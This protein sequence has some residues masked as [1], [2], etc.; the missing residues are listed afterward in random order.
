MISDKHRDRFWKIKELYDTAEADLKNIGRDNQALVVTGINQCRYVGQHLLRAMTATDE[1]VI[2]E[3]LDAALRHTQRAIYDTNDSGIQYYV[4]KIDEIR[5]EHFP[6]V[7]F[8]QIVDSYGDIV[9][10][11]EEAKTLTATTAESL[12]NRE[13]RSQFYQKSREHVEKLQKYY[14]LLNAYRPDLVR[15]VQKDNRDKLRTWAG[16]A[17]A[18]FSLLGLLLTLA[19]CLNFS[20]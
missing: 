8:S 17:L 1:K 13:N 4:S 5:N 15:A 6:T 12:E 19:S 16:V 7:D 14:S 10:E 11:I 9:K 3:E 2:D 20:G 18:L